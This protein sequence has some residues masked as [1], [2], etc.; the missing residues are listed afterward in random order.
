MAKIL[1]GVANFLSVKRL[2]FTGVLVTGAVFA[3]FLL[4]WR[5]PR[6]APPASAP[7]TAVR[8]GQLL[9]S[10]RA[11]P[12]SFN[13]YVARD[14]ETELIGLLTEA[15]LVRINRST[16]ELE[17]W[18]AERWE[19]GADGRTYTLH[20]R[21][22]VQ[23]SDGA[24]F[25]AGDVLFSLDAAFDPGAAGVVAG[26]LA[27]AGQRIRA[28]APDEHTVVLTYPAPYGPGL[29]L[30]DG[31]PILP[32]HTLD[33]ALRAGTF[34][35]AWNTKTPAADLVGTG[36]FVLREYQ[37]GQRIVFERNPRYWRHDPRGQS[38][39]YLDRLVLEVVTDRDDE[40]ARLE[41]RAID[42]TADALRPEDLLAARRAQQ[43]GTLTVTELGVA[44]EADAFWFCLK[45]DA[46]KND[47]RF[48]FVQKPEFRQA[49][50][51]ALDRE[52]FVRDV[53]LGEGVPVWGPVT[54]GNKPWFTPNLPRYPPDVQKAKDLLTSIGLED[55]NGNGIV[56]DA[57][58]TE[59]RFTVITERGVKSYE[60]GTALLR[61]SAAAVGVALDIVPLEFG[62]VVQRL[63]ACNYDAMFMRPPATGIDPVSNLD[64][65]LS[66]GSA[67]WWNPEQ[68]M[69][70]TDWE[71]QIDAI[72]QQQ[73]SSTDDARRHQLFN[74]A[75]RILADNVPVVYLAAPRIY[76]AHSSRVKNVVPSVLRPPI[77]WNADML[78]VQ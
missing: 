35:R 60:R 18:L 59:A 23:W 71:R 73:A 17:P 31:V 3:I 22:D 7:P 4:F 37:P 45:S 68:R 56:E 41:A 24:P 29:E 66:S 32:K 78:A 40:L 12:R 30:L 55:R 74:Q 54:P 2:R 63:T 20:L 67:H 48:A 5:S 49:L 25:T 9:G 46:K 10:I 1:A 62:A 36:P 16:F 75:Q 21:S 58:G 57:A 51:H 47:K 65:W 61:E 33:A 39:P 15:P 77:L 70:A 44:T 13:P 50:S 11:D 26:R 53:Y 43:Q 6:P 38:L 34:A 19:S 42:V 27:V 64:F 28:T 8:G 14:E 76:A 72:M 69:P 52:A